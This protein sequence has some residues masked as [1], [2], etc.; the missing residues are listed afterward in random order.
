MH[1]AMYGERLVGQAALDVLMEAV[2]RLGSV[3]DEKAVAQIVRTAARRLTGADGVSVVL[4]QDDRVLYVDEDAM[5][6]LWKGQSFP[7][8]SCISGWA[9]LNRQTVVISDVSVD[10]RIPLA[11]YKPTFVKSLVMAPVGMPEPKASIGAYWA[12]VRRPSDDE[13]HALETIARAASVALENVRLRRELDGALAR[14]EGSERAQAVFLAQMSRNIRAPLSGLSAMAELLHRAQTDPRQVQLAASLRTAADDVE[15]L[16]REVLEFAQVEGAQGSRYPAP[17]HLEA[18]VRVA[19][20]P[21]V[22]EASRRGLGFSIEIEPEAAQI[23]V[24]DGAHVQK[25]V[26]LLVAY[27]VKHTEIGSVHVGIRQEA[28]A[29]VRSIFALSVTVQG[30]CFSQVAARIAGGERPQSGAGLDLAVGE[31][32]VRAMGGALEVAATQ[33]ESGMLTARFPL[34]LPM[35]E[36]TERRLA[37]RR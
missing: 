7:I 20:A 22:T 23:F 5:A 33:G 34:D 6:P 3:E 1:S 31:A 4:R 14:A 11:A 15:R 16:M 17:F 24:G 28:E 37:G 36:V 26:D 27:A 9:M 29:G 19:A 12:A 25:L 13:V 10:P 2:E 18:A 32:I 35:D 30:A 21:H 8:E